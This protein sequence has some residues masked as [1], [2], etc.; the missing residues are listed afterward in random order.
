M[1]KKIEE[2]EK[3]TNMAKYYNLTFVIFGLLALYCLD[4]YL[5]WGG[6]TCLVND[7][8]EMEMCL[9]KKAAGR[10][11]LEGEGFSDG[12]SELEKTVELLRKYPSGW[13]QSHKGRQ[14]LTPV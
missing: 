5:T 3:N 4:F 8:L 12:R 14:L 11:N 10:R 6:A 7:K 9:E 13:K 2:T 1:A